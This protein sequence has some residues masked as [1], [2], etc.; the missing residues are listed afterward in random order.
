MPAF[1]YPPPPPPERP[2]LQG[3]VVSLALQGGASLG[4]YTWGV[5]DALLEDGRL[6]IEGATGSSAGAINAAALGVGLATG[7]RAGGR[8]RLRAFWEG[9]AQAADGRRRGRFDLLRTL[10][11]SL[12]RLRSAEAF[13]A[14]TTRLVT[15]FHMDPV[16][17]DPLRGTLGQTLDLSALGRPEA[18]KI[19]VNVTDVQTGQPEVFGG[20]EI[21][22]DVICASCAVPFL[23]QPLEIGGRWFWD[24]GL[25]GNP[26]IYPVLYGC[27]ACDV[28]LVE[29]LPTKAPGI[30]RTAAD[31]IS[32]T[33]ELASSA[34]LVRE[35]RTI[36]FVTQLIREAPRPGMREIRLHHIPAHP[37]L[38]TLDGRRSFRADVP[39]FHRLRDLGREAGHS[40]LAEAVTAAPPPVTADSSRSHA[41]RAP[42]ENGASPP[43]AAT[44]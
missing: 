35:L 6:T 17:M 26:A 33:M 41:A 38:A 18:P 9:L 27:E 34:G 20:G 43:R 19:Y 23:F 4:A 13:Y 5:L 14:L 11:R 24:G 25:I 16:T 29:T 31:V 3:R 2:P 10:L 44:H 37:A 36:R 30:P 28:V 12:P 40:W 15:D 8:D 32:R 42:R 39:Y 7:G 21:S 22:A 1:R